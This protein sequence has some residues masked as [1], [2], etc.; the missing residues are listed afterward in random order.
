MLSDSE[1][2]LVGGVGIGLG[3]VYFI[4]KLSVTLGGVMGK[5]IDFAESYM[6]FMQCMVFLLFI[7][8]IFIHIC[9]LYVAK[10]HYF[11]IKKD[12]NKYYTYLYWSET[13]SVLAALSLLFALADF[14]A[15]IAAWKTDPLETLK[16]SFFPYWFYDTFS[17]GNTENN[18]LAVVWYYPLFIL[19]TVIQL[20]SYNSF[21]K[22]KKRYSYFYPS[23]PCSDIYNAFSTR[24]K[25]KNPHSL[26]IPKDDLEDIEVPPCEAI[27]QDLNKKNKEERLR[28]LGIGKNLSSN[29]LYVI[30]PGLLKKRKNTFI[31]QAEIDAEESGSFSGE[32]TVNDMLFFKRKKEAELK[33]E[34]NKTD[35]GI[36]EIAVEKAAP[37]AAEKPKEKPLD[38]EIPLDFDYQSFYRARDKKEEGSKKAEENNLAPCPFCGTLNTKDREE[39][40]FCGAD[41]NNEQ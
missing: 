19:S 9:M 28:A 17:N 10:K 38:Q 35:S 12:F 2:Y 16:M 39:C 5:R 30:D 36:S 14:V 7:G 21:Y 23:V 34:E 26:I 11:K 13:L 1:Y 25:N 20:I 29:S 6:L 8:L 18:S 4:F 27:P 41:L 15:Y 37:A 22:T 24:R 32:E 33:K 31:T 40:I 3:F